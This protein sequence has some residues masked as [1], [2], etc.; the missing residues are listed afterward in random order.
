[1]PVL[2]ESPV[3]SR[4]F[5]EIN[6]TV[7]ANKNIV[8]DLPAVHSNKEGKDQ[9]SIQSSNIPDLGH[10]MGRCPTHKNTSY[11]RALRGQTFPSR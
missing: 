1:M 2:I 8:S 3:Q 7:L 6:D 5:V 4:D 10:H 11:T 9:E